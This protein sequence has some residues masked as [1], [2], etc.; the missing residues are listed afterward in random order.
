MKSLT[1]RQRILASFG[2]IIGLV[3]LMGTLIKIVFQTTPA[4]AKEVATEFPS[5]PEI[6]K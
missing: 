6:E 3:A 1:I 2:L 4:D 5:P